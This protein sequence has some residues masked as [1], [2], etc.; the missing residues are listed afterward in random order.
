M[1]QD[2]CAWSKDT[3]CHVLVEGRDEETVPTSLSQSTRL[4]SPHLAGFSP[5]RLRSLEKVRSAA[6]VKGAQT[7]GWTRTPAPQW[8]WWA[9]LRTPWFY[10]WGKG[11]AAAAA[12]TTRWTH[13]TPAG[14]SQTF[15]LS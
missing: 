2:R 13:T 15:S 4:P 6:S 14:R 12:R 7:W 3:G 10:G 8:P 11:A 1:G 5:S 9:P